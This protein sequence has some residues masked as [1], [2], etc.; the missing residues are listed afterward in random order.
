MEL[1]R[2]CMCSGLDSAPPNG[3]NKL[4][5]QR[6]VV[7]AVVAYNFTIVCRTSQPHRCN[8]VPFG[9]WWLW[10][11]RLQMIKLHF[12]GINNYRWA[13]WRCNIYTLFHV[14]AGEIYVICVINCMAPSARVDVLKGVSTFSHRV[15]WDAL[16]KFSARQTFGWHS[17]GH[18][19]I[20]FFFGFFFFS[21][22]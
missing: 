22:I 19:F 2:F 4:N 16:S 10:P 15:S 5:I 1:F 8:G 9:F 13:L 20:I 21:Y 18:N 17:F 14:N 11:H 7:V 12:K 6:I 3:Q